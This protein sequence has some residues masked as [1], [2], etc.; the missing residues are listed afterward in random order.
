MDSR[1]LEQG[2]Y[3]ERLAL[4]FLKKKGLKYI[5]SNFRCKLG[6]IDLI[7]EHRKS[8]VFIEV[9]YRKN[10]AHG[11]PGE[12]VTTHKQK[13][14]IKTAEFYLSGLKQKIPPCR[15]D[16]IAISGPEKKETIEWI[17]NAFQPA[18]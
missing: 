8:L 17:E 12:T 4:K 9:R 3:A 10:L 1:H 16:V 5:T 15:F 6:E 7:M 2:K 14:L 13:K 18:V 11:H